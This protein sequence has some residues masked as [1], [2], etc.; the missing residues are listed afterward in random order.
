MNEFISDI[1]VSLI[2]LLG[3]VKVILVNQFNIYQ[4][5]V[6][7]ILGATLIWLL[8]N[9]YTRLKKKKLNMD[10]YLSCQDEV[11]SIGFKK[12]TNSDYNCRK[13]CRQPDQDI[14]Y[15]GWMDC[16]EWLKSKKTDNENK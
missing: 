1:H 11:V 14:Y 4:G 7:F 5:G 12:A 8:Y 10:N 16:Y 6:I 3:L 9:K 2:V 15:S 13:V